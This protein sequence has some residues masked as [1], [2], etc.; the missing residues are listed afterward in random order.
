MLP[1]KYINEA[2]KNIIIYE[3]TLRRTL[4]V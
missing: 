2:I 4:Y 1:N 3:D